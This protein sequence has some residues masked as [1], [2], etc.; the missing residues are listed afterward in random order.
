MA[1]REPSTSRAPGGDHPVTRPRPGSTDSI[2]DVPGVRVGQ[3]SIGVGPETPNG[4]TGVT[5]IVVPGGALGAIDVRGG[6]P[7]TR[8]SDTLDARRSGER[9][10]AVLLVGRSVF[11][12]AAADGATSELEERGVGIIVEREEGRLVFPIVPAAVIFDALHGDPA[13]RPSAEDGR[14]AVAVALDADGEPARPASGTAG[15]GTG[16]SVGGLV[17][18]RRK[19]GVGHASLVATFGQRQLVVGALVVVNSAGGPVRGRTSL[20]GPARRPRPLPAFETIS[21]SRGQTTLAVVATN[22]RLSKA[23]LSHVATMAHDGFARAIEPVHTAV[24]GDL[25][26]CLGIPEAEATPG[27]EVHEWPPAATSIVGA[28]A[29]DAV[30]RA[31]ADALRSA[32]SSGGLDPV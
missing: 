18:D 10:H 21:S 16:A 32:T 28:M 4:S 11:G 13:V 30:E 6:A 12:L 7:G 31:I 17:G 23:Q 22:A 14:R 20:L 24:D 9:I 15:A 27:V 29:A 8:E 26:I 2:V 5:A 3:V 19:G 1:T 25:A